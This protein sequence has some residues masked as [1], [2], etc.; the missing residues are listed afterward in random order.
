[1]STRHCHFE[2]QCLLAL[3]SQ[4]RTD[5]L[6]ELQRHAYDCSDCTSR[7]QQMIYVNSRLLGAGNVGHRH[8]HAPKGSLE[9]FMKRAI[10]EGVASKP[11]K[12]DPSR[13]ANLKL[14]IASLLA[15][16]LIAISFELGVRFWPARSLPAVQLA[17]QFNAGLKTDSSR[18]TASN[19]RRA[20]AARRVTHR[21]ARKFAHYQEHRPETDLDSDSEVRIGFGPA[22]SA[23]ILVQ[24]FRSSS[25]T[26]TLRPASFH[27][28]LGQDLSQRVNADDSCKPDFCFNPRV[29]F[30]ASYDSPHMPALTWTEMRFSTTSPAAP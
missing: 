29:A 11:Q 17:A 7:I 26:T 13:S 20:P 25:L 27:L 15:F 14:S 19:D 5:E 24:R 12:L 22:Q 1:M 18:F 21:R 4:L 23:G 8:F 6:D 30:L 28:S 9:R 2:I 10:R 3:C 16:A